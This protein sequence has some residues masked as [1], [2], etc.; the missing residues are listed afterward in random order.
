MAASYVFNDSE[1]T[2]TC[3]FPVVP[4]L[5]SKGKSMLLATTS[6]AESIPHDGMDVQFNVNIYVPIAQWEARAKK[7]KKS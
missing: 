3:T 4:K 1:R 5:S 2:I 7:S 6:G